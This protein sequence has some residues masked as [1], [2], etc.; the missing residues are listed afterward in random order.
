MNKATDNH[1]TYW[2]RVVRRV[3]ARGIN[4][5]ELAKLIG[6]SRPL[7][8]QLADGRTSNP[9]YQTGA[10]LLALANMPADR[11]ARVREGAEKITVL[12]ESP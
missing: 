2:Q 5:P 10:A 7:I 12:T 11:L 9:S 3:Y 4:P 1:R 6:C 8:Y